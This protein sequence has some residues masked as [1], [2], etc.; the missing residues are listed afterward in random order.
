MHITDNEGFAALHRSA[1]NG[2]YE[3]IKFFISE[4]ID[5]FHKTT[6]GMNCL[7]IAAV[8]GHVSL[9]KSLINM[10]NFDLNIANNI[11]FTA[12]HRSAQNGSY[13]LLKFFVEK[14]TNIF[15]KTER[16]M[17][18]LHIAA[19]S[20]HLDLCKTLINEHNFDVNMTDS[21]G[22]TALHFSAENGSYDL[23]KLFADKGTDIYLKTEEGMN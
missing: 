4:R 11:G 18:C 19:L 20:G 21:E 2:S 15:G 3:L 1:Q 14:G 8:R 17:N 5:I 23:V 7:H 13:E 16:G 22:F 9:C 10:H 12:L 6:C